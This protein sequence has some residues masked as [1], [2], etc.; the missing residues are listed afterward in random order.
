MRE[1]LTSTSENAASVTSRCNSSAVGVFRE[2]LKRVATSLL[3]EADKGAAD[4][5]IVN[6]DAIP[7]TERQT[8]LTGEY[9]AHLPQR[10]WLI[11]K[12]LQALLTKNNI[13]AGIMKSKIER[14]ALK[15]FNCITIDRWKRLRNRDD[16]RI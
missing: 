12:E 1:T 11:R 3:T 4:G 6:A 2:A 14:A 10:A 15:P 5:G 7:N 8:T 16:S 9:P 13:E